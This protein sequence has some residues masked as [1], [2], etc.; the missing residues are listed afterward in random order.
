MREREGGEVPGSALCFRG[1]FSPAFFARARWR[2]TKHRN[3]L[4][5]RCPTIRMPSCGLLSFS[6]KIVQ[7]KAGT[8]VWTSFMSR[9]LFDGLEKFKFQ[10]ACEM[11][12]LCHSLP[13]GERCR[14]LDLLPVKRAE[15]T[16]IRIGNHGSPVSNV[17]I[18][19]TSACVNTRSPQMHFKWAL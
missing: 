6:R 7:R 5:P 1:S 13:I 2:T 9:L 14:C 19:S 18:S 10:K 11:Q 16:R 4:A 12:G 8:G 17:R 3:S 15:K